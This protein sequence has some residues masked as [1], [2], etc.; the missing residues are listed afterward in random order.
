VADE[1]ER[2]G[3]CECVLMCAGLLQMHRNMRCCAQRRTDVPSL[4]GDFGP[5]E[6]FERAGELERRSAG[7]RYAVGRVLAV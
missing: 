6:R 1:R 4:L 5:F 2:C 3:P 7:S